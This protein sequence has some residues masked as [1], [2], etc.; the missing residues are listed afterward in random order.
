LRGGPD[1]HLLESPD[2]ELLREMAGVEPDKQ[3]ANAVLP[4][5]D[6]RA[7]QRVALGN[8]GGGIAV[9]TWPGELQRQAQ[10]LYDGGRAPRLLAAAAADGWDV[11]RRP[12]LA[13]WR[14]RPGERLYMHPAPNLTA[15]EYVARW[16]GEDADKIRG[17]DRD[18]VRAELWPWLLH[19]GYATSVDASELD[20]FLERVKKANRDVHLRPGLAVIRRWTRDDVEALRQRGELAREI[21]DAL[22]R[23]LD[24]LDDPPLPAAST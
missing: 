6:K 11:E 21:R 13:Y 8:V 5:G 4:D 16:A 18:E 17:Y 14:S 20:P 23:I 2:R 12:H 22:G 7:T 24:A 19:R 3:G 15:A 10:R 9:F 1:D